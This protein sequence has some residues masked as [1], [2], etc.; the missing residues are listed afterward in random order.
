LN[1]YAHD[2]PVIPPAGQHY[3]TSLLGPYL[4]KMVPDARNHLLG[5]LGRHASFVGRHQG[6]GSDES[7][8]RG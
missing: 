3:L 6:I 4:G 7:V 8:F 2:P 1:G 5:T